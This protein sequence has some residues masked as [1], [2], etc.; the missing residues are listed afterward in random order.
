MPLFQSR[1]YRKTLKGKSLEI[2]K[3]F[4][5]KEADEHKFI[6]PVSK[7]HERVASATGVSKSSIKTKKGNAKFAGWGNHLI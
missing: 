2:V 7:V 1:L 6:I 3:K 4:M 5:Q